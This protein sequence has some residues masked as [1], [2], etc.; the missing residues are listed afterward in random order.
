VYKKIYRQKNTPTKKYTDM[1]SYNKLLVLPMDIS[2]INSIPWHELQHAYGTAEDSPKYLIDLLNG[3]K[4]LIDEAIY[5]FLHSSAC[6]QYS[7]YSCTPYVVRCVVFILESKY[8]EIEQTCEILG[9][10]NACTH[11]ARVNPELRK[12]IIQGAECFKKYLKH[13]DPKVIKNIQK[14][15]VF[16]NE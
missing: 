14:L 10:L 7:T 4:D 1:L 13:S 3:N 9:F 8:F 16:C 11:S 2:T 15:L 12:E 6:H 5:G